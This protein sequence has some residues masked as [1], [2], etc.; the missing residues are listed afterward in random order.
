MRIKKTINKNIEETVVE[1]IKCDA[2]SKSTTA[3]FTSSGP[4]DW[5]DSIETVCWMTN[6]ETDE[7]IEVIFCPNCFL[8]MSEQF[9]PNK[10]VKWFE[11]NKY[12][13]Y[14]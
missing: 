8:L 13:D 14:D 12:E 6:Y 9:I 7:T 3:D 11:G 10:Y 2:C 4:V 5:G 1:K